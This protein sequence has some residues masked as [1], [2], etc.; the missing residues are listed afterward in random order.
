MLIPANQA[1]AP[2]TR[3]ASPAEASRTAAAP[4]PSP[5]SRLTSGPTPAMRSSAPGVDASPRKRAI[6]P[7]THSV[8][9]STGTPLRIARTAWATSC[10]SKP[11]R[12]ATAAPSPATTYAQGGLPGYV[13]GKRL[14]DS[15]QASRPKMIRTLQWTPMSM[16]AKRPSR[17]VAV[18]MS[19]PAVHPGRR[20]GHRLRFHPVSGGH[21]QPTSRVSGLGRP[22]LYGG[23]RAGV[24]V[25]D[26]HDR[27]VAELVPDGLT[28]NVP[29][30]EPWGRTRCES[31]IRTAYAPCSSMSR[32]GCHSLRRVTNDLRRADSQRPTR[33]FP[34]ASIAWIR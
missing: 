12:N 22:V 17:K 26:H 3:P 2:T 19:P 1:N 23:Q 10:A 18:T 20:I 31:R 25:R 9:P 29:T 6:P 33:R 24:D 5:M 16:P 27:G 32:P 14:A 15:I 30:R 13:A 34:F 11:N 8:M 4:N 21:I 7:N 28:P